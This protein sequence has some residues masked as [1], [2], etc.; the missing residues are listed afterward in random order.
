MIKIVI[1]DKPAIYPNDFKVSH[2]DI[3]A[4]QGVCGGSL[5]GAGDPGGAV[6]GLLLRPPLPP[7]QGRRPRRPHDLGIPGMNILLN[8]V[9]VIKFCKAC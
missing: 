4:G 7:H 2:P 8:N 9:N 1:V 3:A 6:P 5:A